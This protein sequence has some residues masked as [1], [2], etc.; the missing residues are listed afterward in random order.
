MAYPDE[1]EHPWAIPLRAAINRAGGFSLQDTWVDPTDVAAM[2]A[3]GGTNG[4]R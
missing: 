4:S 2:A 3:V 1:I